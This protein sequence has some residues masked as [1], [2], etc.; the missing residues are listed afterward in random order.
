MGF[1]LLIQ[2]NT[3]HPNAT[4]PIQTGRYWEI[5]GLQSDKQ[6]DAT[7]FTVDLTLP[8][9]FIPDGNDKICRYTGSGWDCA[10][11]SYTGTSLTRKDIT[12]FSDWAVGNDVGP[13][14]VELQMF[15]ATTAFA[16][17]QV[18]LLLFVGW[19]AVGLVVYWFRK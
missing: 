14:A 7:G 10:V 9:T 6:S 19:I 17:P 16:I 15:T 5:R 2:R 11:S 13:S 8:A 3:N 18:L 4:P 1:V 12:S